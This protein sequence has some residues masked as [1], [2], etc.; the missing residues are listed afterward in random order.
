M[1]VVDEKSPTG[2]LSMYNTEFIE[3]IAHAARANF[4]VQG[5]EPVANQDGRVWKLLWMGNLIVSSPRMQAIATG[6]TE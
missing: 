2:Y 6:L 1:V 4:E 5:P 3:L